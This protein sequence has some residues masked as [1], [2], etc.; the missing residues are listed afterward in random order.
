VKRRERE[1]ER[2]S[3]SRFVAVGAR[4]PARPPAAAVA[5]AAVAPRLTWLRSSD[6]VF[7]RSSYA[8][9]L[10]VGCCGGGGGGCGEGGGGRD[11]RKVGVGRGRVS[12]FGRLVL[13]L[14][15]LL[16]QRDAAA[17]TRKRMISAHKC[18][19]R[20]TRGA[21]TS[22]DRKGRE[23]VAFCLFCRLSPS[24]SDGRP[25]LCPACCC[26]CWRS[27]QAWIDA[28]LSYVRRRDIGVLRLARARASSSAWLLPTARVL[29][30]TRLFIVVL[31]LCAR[32]SGAG[33]RSR[34][35][36]RTH[37]AMWSWSKTGWRKEKERGKV[38]REGGSF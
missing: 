11:Q 10:A 35:V 26:C 25:P 21:A 3:S 18:P 2:A 7:S 29:L 34:A 38:E 37:R 12:F 9:T 23:S 31:S 8:L 30:P 1:R 20:G 17:E 22:P 6:L 4:S 32:R 13:V 24:L 16:R 27:Q 15:L 28:S 36:Q 19:V 33:D 14:V 5:A